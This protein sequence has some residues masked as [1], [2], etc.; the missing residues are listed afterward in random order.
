MRPVKGQLLHLRGEPLLTRTVRGVDV[1]LVPRGDG[2]LI[3]GATVEEKGDD[4]RATAG[5]VYELL[6]AA[7]ELAARRHRAGVHRG[8]G[9][10]ASRDARQRARD[11]PLATI[12]V[13]VATGH[14]RNGILLAPV[15]ADLV[16]ELLTTGRLPEPRRGVLTAS[17]SHDHHGER[18]PR[19]RCPKARRWRDC[20]CA[21]GTTGAS[22]GW[23]SP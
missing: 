21:A 15:T 11:R 10:L 1:Y 22:G 16:V 4:L 20:W 13:V 19:P 3:V 9:R 17:G 2:R 7:Y 12:G 18:R 6:R 23:P 5:G 8:G 14:Y